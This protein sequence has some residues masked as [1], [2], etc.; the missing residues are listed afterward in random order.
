MNDRITE[1][2]T[3]VAGFCRG[4]DVDRG[5]GRLAKAKGARSK[6]SR[7]QGRELEGKTCETGCKNG[8]R[9]ERADR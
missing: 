3:Q 6:L 1:L 2:T 7:T 9:T 8:Q 5:K 4:C